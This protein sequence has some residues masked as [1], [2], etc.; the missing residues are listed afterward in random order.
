MSTAYVIEIEEEAAGIVAA[1]GKGFRFYAAIRAFSALEG[2][3]FHTP[4]Q[5][6]A[7]AREH[8]KRRRSA[9]GRTAIA[10]AS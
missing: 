2:A 1:E 10:G 9:S 5:A 7:A 6:E 3:F 8:L 4:K